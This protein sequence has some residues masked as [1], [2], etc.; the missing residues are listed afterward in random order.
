MGRD[1]IDLEVPIHEVRIAYAYTTEWNDP[2]TCEL[3][4]GSHL[5]VR[6]MPPDEGETPADKC[7]YR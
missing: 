5:R 7:V 2:D 6:E 1:F 3:P 4:R